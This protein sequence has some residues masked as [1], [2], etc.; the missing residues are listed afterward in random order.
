MLLSNKTSADTRPEM[1]VQKP[2]DLIGGDV[3]STLEEA[4]CKD[5]DRV[6]VSGDELGKEV[7]ELYLFL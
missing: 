3:A 1:V 6:C 5:R 2:R 4:L 7:C